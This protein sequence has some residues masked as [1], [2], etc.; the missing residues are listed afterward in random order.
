LLKAL[1][2]AFASCSIACIRGRYL[3]RFG[4]WTEPRLP[5]AV[6]G[7]SP[8]QDRSRKSRLWRPPR[9]PIRT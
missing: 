6:S 7:G 1:S 2:L 3:R 4:V 9:T 5:G 8:K